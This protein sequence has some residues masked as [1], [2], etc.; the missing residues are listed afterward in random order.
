VALLV[1]GIVI[2]VTR[3]SGPPPLPLPGIGR[4][5]PP[6]DPFAY[7]PGRQTEFEAR[8]AAGT[9]RVLFTKSPGGA[10][11][12]AARVA[13]F[14]S[15]IDAATAGSGV[16]PATVEAIVF[17][18]SAGRP[19]V[20]AGTDPSA[21]AGLTQILAETGQSLLGMHI[22]LA[23][24]RRLTKAIERAAAIGDAAAIARLE[25]QRA[26]IDDRFNP[27]R[28]L[29]ATV[30]YLRLARQRL[31]RDDLAVVS[32]HMGIGNL[33][34]VLG[35]YNGGGAVPYAQLYFDTAPDRH[36]AAFKLL[37]GFG[38]DSS[39]YYWRV[40]GAIQ[41]MHLYRADPGALTRLANLESSGASTEQVLHPPDR[42]PSFA[43][44]SALR[45]AY[46]NRTVLP[47]PA[48][49]GRLGLAYDPG[50]GSAASRVGA[51]TALYRGLRPSALD[52]LIEL[53][54]RVRALSGST[55][56]LTIT[57]T[58]RDQ[59]YEGALGGSDPTASGGYSPQTTGYA[60][61]IARSYASQAQARALQNLLDR[62]Q[63]LNL[64]A[65][66][67]TPAVIQVTVAG[68]ASKVI[69]DGP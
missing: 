7:R 62:L 54:A 9:A 45:D 53:A 26:K 15:Q 49:S 2:A 4:P 46:A 37:Q 10:A 41:I 44:Q 20:I 57:S 19:N 47:L 50:M 33:Q 64:I 8:A 40:L 12:T 68:D 59:R 32:Y 39:L 25:R 58:V 6:G 65:W 69:V 43:D 29:A 67:R 18:E 11:A 13:P 55:G 17:L 38:D 24:S 31:G 28:A 5:A 30:R 1:I 66:V 21:A 22:D 16:S 61:D 52:L 63:A 34:N 51:Q 56:T 27:P 3:G 14:R 35:N 48:N 60:F 36:A 23:Q 42:T